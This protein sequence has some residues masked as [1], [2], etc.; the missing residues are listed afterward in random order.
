[1]DNDKANVQQAP[2]TDKG[3]AEQQS[4]E[5]SPDVQTADVPAE[6]SKGP[7]DKK[8]GT[9]FEELAAKKGFKSI[10]DLAKAYANLESQNKKVEM[11]NAELQKLFFEAQ[12]RS[13]NQDTQPFSQTL[14]ENLDV[15]KQALEELD[16]FVSE[17]VKEREEKLR[18]EF[19][20]E[21]EKKELKEVIKENPDFV[22][23]AKDVKEVKKKYPDMSFSEA[24]IFAK[25][26]KGDLQKEVKAQGLKEGAKAVIEQQKAQTAPVKKAEEKKIGPEELLEGASRRW[27]PKARGT[28]IEVDQ[29]A[30]AEIEQVEKEL[31][32]TPL[33]KT[34]IGL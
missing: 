11:T 9:T 32:G 28:A 18:Q 20:T 23:Y 25:A 16:R 5:Q 7:S 13:Q 10:D 12:Q 21:L 29:R 4:I 31:F 34:S 22:N 30:V 26:Q 6:V 17:K 19:K 3:Q 14:P 33:D 15:D 24:Y 27:A 1:M 2:D 8:E